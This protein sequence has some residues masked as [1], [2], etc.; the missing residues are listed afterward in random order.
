M[1]SKRICDE[2]KRIHLLALIHND[3]KKKHAEF[4]V[5]LDLI[6]FAYFM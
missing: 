3:N 4:S 5:S 6:A 1:K 2:N